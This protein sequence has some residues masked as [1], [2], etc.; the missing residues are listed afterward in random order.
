[1]CLLLATGIWILIKN[2]IGSAA[3]DSDGIFS[4]P[5]ATPV[6]EETLEPRK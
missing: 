1:M 6:D 4:A 5:R 3:N 2:H